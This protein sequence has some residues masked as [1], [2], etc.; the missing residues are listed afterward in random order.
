MFHGEDEEWPVHTTTSAPSTTT[1]AT[2][3]TGRPTP[4]T[5][6]TKSPIECPDD[7][8]VTADSFSGLAQVV[9]KLPSAHGYIEINSFYPPGTYPISIPLPAGRKC[10]FKITVHSKFLLI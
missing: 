1:P 9:Y 4:T 2:S 6:T 10:V 8:N 7:I 3:T 5:T